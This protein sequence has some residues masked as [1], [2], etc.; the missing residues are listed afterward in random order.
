MK[1]LLLLSVMLLIGANLLLGTTAKKT[2]NSTTN[3]A[4]SVNSK[5]TGASKTNTAKT[6]VSKTGTTKSPTGTKATGSGNTKTNSSGTNNL[7]KNTNFIRLEPNTGPANKRELTP[8]EIQ[9]NTTTSTPASPENTVPA[10]TSEKP[11]K[12][13]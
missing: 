9:Q 5:N 4:K 6:K 2:G 13:P 7:D 10:T 11:R 8:E 12:S 3:R 1:K